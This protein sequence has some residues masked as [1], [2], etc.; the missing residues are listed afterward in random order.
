MNYSIINLGHDY[1][2]KIIDFAAARNSFIRRL[3]DNQYILWKSD[4]EEYSKE[5]LP[6]LDNLEPKYP[7]YAIRRI[8]LLEGKYRPS[9]NP[10]F[11]PFIVSNKV[12]YRGAVHERVYPR[13][14]YGRI[15]YPTVI[16]NHVG[17]SLYGQTN[18][19]ILKIAL[20]RAYLVMRYGE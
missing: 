20:Q 2:G 9:Q 18:T 1:P 5:L 3:P 14:P 4:D 17:P 6:F 10:D 11:E 7:Y 16:H 12:R 19:N 13:K 15:S 8:N